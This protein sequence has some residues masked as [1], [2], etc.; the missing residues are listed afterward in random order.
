MSD[1]LLLNADA[2]PISFL[3]PST[4]CWQNAMTRLYKGEAEVLHTYDDWE[5][6]SPSVTMLVPSVIILKKQIKKV[7]TWIARDNT[8][9]RDL[10]FLRD[11]YVCQ[12]C[13]DQFPR[14]SL[15]LDH[16]TPRYN[17]GRTKWDNVSTSC[18]ACN[19]KRGHDERIQPHTKPY[20]PT[21]DQLIS[22][23]MKFPITIP[24]LEWN[25]YLGW[26]EN[27]VRVINPKNNKKYSSLNDDFNFG[28]FRLE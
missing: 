20:R 10:V 22:N 17:G 12:Y 2:R 6:H 16:V 25:Y 28:L 14:K 13:G 18:S 1:V 8:A 21:Y 5:V 27:L 24:A 9:Q 3:P 15:T 4:E 7:R 11:L 19:C 26:E 23:M